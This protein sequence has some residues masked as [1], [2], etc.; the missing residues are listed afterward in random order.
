MTENVAAGEKQL[1][2]FTLG[3]ELYAIDIGIVREIFQNQPI[4]RVPG[5]PF[6]IEGV[7]NLRGSVI[8]I[9]DLRKRF[10]ISRLEKGKDTRIM[11]VSCKGKDIGIIVDSVSEVLRVPE[12]S[13]EPS[14]STFTKGHLEHLRGIVKLTGSLIILLDMDQVIFKQDMAVIYSTEYKIA[15][16]NVQKG[17]AALTK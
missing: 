16:S 11:V 7:I 17:E 2:V 14:T 4:T 3:T 6:S 8:P 9:V 12:D 15:D 5:T 10:Q 1:V 13:I